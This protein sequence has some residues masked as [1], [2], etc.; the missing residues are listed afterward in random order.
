MNFQGIDQWENLTDCLQIVS[1]YVKNENGTVDYYKICGNYVVEAIEL[2][3]KHI[4]IVRFAGY[5]KYDTKGVKYSGI[6][7]KTWSLQLGLNIA[8]STLMERANRSIK[9]NVIMS[10]QAAQKP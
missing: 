4:P 1:Y 5:E 6:V 2:P 7:D 3:I 9:A 10:T 8:Y